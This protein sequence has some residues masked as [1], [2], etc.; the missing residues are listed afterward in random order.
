VKTLTLQQF[1]ERFGWIPD[2]AV[3]GKYAAAHDREIIN[4][5]CAFERPER[6]LEIGINEGRT[7]E[8]LLRCSPWIKTYCGMDVYHGLVP[9]LDVQRGETPGAG[10]VARLVNDPRLKVILSAFGA[11]SD[12]RKFTGD[13]FGFVYIDADHSE[14]GVETDTLYAESVAASHACFVWHDYAPDLPGVV[15]FLD[16]YSQRK[17]ACHVAGTRIV[18]GFVG[19]EKGATK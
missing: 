12:M 15:R 14:R 7:A 18:F 19:S 9:A 10:M 1:K 8:L 11:C 5:L 17:D 13:G 16:R 4:S 6:V 3:D 2:A